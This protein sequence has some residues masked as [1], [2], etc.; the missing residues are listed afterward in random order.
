METGDFVRRA[1]GVPFIVG[2]RDWSGWDCW[3]LVYLAHRELLGIDVPVLAADYDAASSVG[4]LGA[5]VDRERPVWREVERPAFGDVALFRVCRFE[6]HVGFVLE[7]GQMIHC[8]HGAGT[9]CER[10][11]TLLWA[12]RRAGYFRHA[13]R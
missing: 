7:R 6:T 3:G 8:L 9:L 12:R 2:G 5:L 4:D 1:L 10:V 11:D 13:Q